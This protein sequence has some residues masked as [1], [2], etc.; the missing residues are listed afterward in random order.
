LAIVVG[1]MVV[2]VSPERWDTVLL[3]LPRGHGL[4]LHD[5]VGTAFVAVGTALL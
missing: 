4:H 2:G 3:D 5:V 1:T